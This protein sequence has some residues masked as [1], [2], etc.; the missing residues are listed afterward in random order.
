[1]SLSPGP[2]TPHGDGFF[3]WHAYDPSCKA[4]LWST[5][6]SS[7]QGTVLFDPI[8]WPKDA[9]LPTAPVLIVLT[10]GNHDRACGGLVAKTKGQVVSTPPEFTAFPLPGAGEAETAFFHPL[11]GTLVVGDA[12]IHL[13]PHG[14]MP[15]PDKY[16]TDP[17]LLRRSL[18]RLLDLPVRRIFFA[19]GDPILQ[20]GAKRIHQLFP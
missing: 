3:T 14:L 1:L 20:D 4:E 2:L 12:L 13:A 17:A 5:C 15:L 7:N 9:P 18:R 10:N 16:C 6:F 8:D 11:S 19:H